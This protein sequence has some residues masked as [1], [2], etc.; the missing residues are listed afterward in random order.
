M[1]V[2][3]GSLRNYGY[4]LRTTNLRRSPRART[5]LVRAFGA[6]H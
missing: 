3:K 6:K 5:V 1:G 4:R 2:L